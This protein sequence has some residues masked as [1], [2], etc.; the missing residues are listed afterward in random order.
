MPAFMPVGTVGTVK[1]LEIEQSRHRHDDPGQY[2]SSDARP[3][4]DVVRDLGGLHQ[5]TGWEGPI[6]TDSGG[7]QLFSLAKMTKV[8]ETRAVFRLH[9]DGRLLELSPERAVEIQE[10]LGSDV[11]MVLDHVVSLPNA[12]SVI[13]DAAERSV[14]WAERCRRGNPDR[15]GPVC[16][17]EGLDAELRVWCAAQL[18]EL[19][20]P[21]YAIGG[22][23][24]WAKLLTRCTVPSTPHY[25]QC[26]PIGRDI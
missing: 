1:G 19:E 22:L 17:R 7:F 23:S 9:I 20:F 26:P 15:S 5:F 13:R 2:L 8:T 16:H 12:P 10:A 25:R 6:L 3:G 21:G 4:E 11:A 14:R 18:A 24:A